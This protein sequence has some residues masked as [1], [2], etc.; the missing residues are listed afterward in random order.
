MATR[1]YSVPLSFEFPLEDEVIGNR[2][3]KG[4]RIEVGEKKIEGL[5]S[6]SAREDSSKPQRPK[7]IEEQPL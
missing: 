5:D 6:K 7:K 4:K 2:T 3:Y 1:D